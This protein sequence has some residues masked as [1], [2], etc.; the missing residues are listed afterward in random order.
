MGK[1][2]PEDIFRAAGG[3]LRMS[4]AIEKG[5][6]RYT[7]YKMRDEGILEQLSRGIYRLSELPAIGNPDLVTV[8]LRIPNAVICLISALAFHNLTTQIPH[9]IDIALPRTARN[10]SLEY[11]AIRVHRF[12]EK[13]WSPGIEE[14]VIDTVPIRIYNAEKTIADC[15]RYR[16]QLGMDIILESLRLY[17]RKDDVKYDKLLEYARINR[18]EKTIY[19]YLEASGK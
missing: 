18:V 19:P 1:G 10:P 4:E 13:T 5:I 2:T 17:A 6:S 11:P 16:N 3:Q 15:F 14:R 9:V 12:S 7:L 8:S